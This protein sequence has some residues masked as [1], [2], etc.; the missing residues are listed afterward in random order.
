MDVANK[1]LKDSQ[2]SAYELQYDFYSDIHII[3]QHWNLA[4]GDKIPLRCEQT[5]QVI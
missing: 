3:S 4:K 2:D 5:P 1:L